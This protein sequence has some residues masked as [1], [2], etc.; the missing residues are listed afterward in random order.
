MKKTS[1]DKFMFYY[2]QVISELDALREKAENH[3]DVDPEDIDR[4]V[5]Y[6]ARRTVE[7]LRYANRYWKE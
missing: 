7:F 5:L 3:F 2:E 6:K 4:S 1:V